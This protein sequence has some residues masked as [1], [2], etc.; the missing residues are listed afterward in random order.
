MLAACRFLN[1]VRGIVR[2]ISNPSLI[3]V[4]RYHDVGLSV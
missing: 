2:L 3:G 1:R 4:T